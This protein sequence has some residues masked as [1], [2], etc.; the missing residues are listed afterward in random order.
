M[1]GLRDPLFHRAVVY[2]CDYNAEGAMGIIINKVFDHLTVDIVLQRLE[3]SPVPRDESISLNKPVFVGG[4]LGTERGF[5]L[6][7]GSQQFNSSILISDNL[8]LTTSKD[9]LETL[10]TPAQP[11]DV[12][13]ALGY[14]SWEK[15]QLE[16]EIKDNAWLT[17][18]ADAHIL[19]KTPIHNRWHDGAKLIGVDIQMM[20]PIAGHA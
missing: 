4:P 6:H 15:G 1:P 3:I 8:V 16:E 17:T 7:N 2:I 14:A 11:P 13:V 20:A 10:G 18:D 19:F 12:L 5:I 9:V